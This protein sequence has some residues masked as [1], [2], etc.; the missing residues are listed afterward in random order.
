[1]NS[2]NNRQKF[3]QIEPRFWLLELN[4]PNA[5][6]WRSQVRLANGRSEFLRYQTFAATEFPH[7]ELC[8]M[9]TTVRR[10]RCRE[11]YNMYLYYLLYMVC[12]KLTCNI[13]S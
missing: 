7:C 9:C 2:D 5:G 6:S 12:T 8:V 1:M 3:K 10:P 13:Q 11:D 4:I